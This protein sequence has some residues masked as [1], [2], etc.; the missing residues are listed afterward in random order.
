M[1]SITKSFLFTLIVVGILEGGLISVAHALSMGS[2]NATGRAELSLDGKIWTVIDR[3]FPVTVHTI[4]RTSDGNLI[5]SFKDRVRVELAEI[6]EVTILPGSENAYVIN[7]TKGELLFSVPPE[8][9][10]EITT[11]DAVVAIKKNDSQR[12][13]HENTGKR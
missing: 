12:P 13:S 10:L 7:F 3:T 6:S 5:F 11:H 1:K 4:F 2:V 9:G 8:E